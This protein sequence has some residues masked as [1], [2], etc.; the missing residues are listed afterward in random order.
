MKLEIERK[1]L[2]RPGKIPAMARADGQRVTQGYLSAKPSVR[3]RL[4]HDGKAWLTIK[5]ETLVEAPSSRTSAPTPV[6]PSRHEYE[7]EIPADDAKGL[8]GLCLYVLDK[9]R[10]RVKVGEHVWEIDEFVGPHRGL[11]MAEI[12]LQRP[13]ESFERPDW[14][15]DEVSDD[16]RYTNGA[17]ARA[18]RAPAASRPAVERAL[19]QLGD[20]LSQLESGKRLGTIGPLMEAASLMAVADGEVDDDEREVIRRVLQK[21]SVDALPAVV[22]D[23]MLASS[24]EQTREMGVERRC[25][26]LAGALIKHDVVR[27][28]VFIAVLVAEISGGIVDRERVVLDRLA[29]KTA[30]DEGTLDWTI[31]AVH[32][33]LG[34]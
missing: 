10:Y 30:T 4:D 34:R 22:A 2:V 3:V 8:L 21:L 33:A 19:G 29:K 14:I 16:G 20:R 7:Y 25:D 13:E 1:F 15:T 18:G 31:A 9:I 28:G 17:L 12:E 26:E 32:E 11:W 5:S 27:E 23:A 24:V 6:A